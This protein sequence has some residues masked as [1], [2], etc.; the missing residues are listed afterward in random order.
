MLWSDPPDEPSEELRTVGARL[1]TA[2]RV[3]AIAMVVTVVLL[4]VL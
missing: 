3:V 1:R 2:G 4:G